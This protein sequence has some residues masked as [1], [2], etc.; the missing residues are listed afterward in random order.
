MS[1]PGNNTRRRIVPRWRDFRSTAKLGELK[2]V[3]LEEHPIK[4]SPIAEHLSYSDWKREPHL[5]NAL[6]LIGSA[7]IFDET[8]EVGD[9][10]L[11]VLLDPATPPLTKKLLSDQGRGIGREV[12]LPPNP[13]TIAGRGVIR[14]EIARIKRELSAFPWDAINWMELARNYTTV[15]VHDRAERSVRVALQLAPENRYVLRSAAR[16]F[17]HRGDLERA[18]WILFRHANSAQDPWLLAPEI[19]VASALGRTSKLAKIGQR[20]LLTDI[21]PTELTELASAL[22][23][24]EVENGNNKGAKRLLKQALMGANENS[25]AQIE[26]LNRQKLGELIDISAANPPLLHEA[27]AWA[28]T[29]KGEWHESLHHAWNWLRDQPFSSHPAMLC[30]YLLSDILELHDEAAKVCSMALLANPTEPMLQNNY[31]F[32]LVNSGKLNEATEVLSRIDIE[33][34]SGISRMVIATVG[35]LAFRTGHPEEGRQQ[36]L[37][38]IEEARKENDKVRAAR[39][40]IYLA[41]E[42]VRARTDNAAKAILRASEMSKDLENA[43]VKW[44]FAQLERMVASIHSEPPE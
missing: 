6:D 44:Q 19:A 30:S 11:Q 8:D 24:V 18:Q 29:I 38:A 34:L 1:L 31:A 16:F 37:A 35:L 4:H 23:T 14:H 12:T 15:G 41:K 20:V 32:A 43:D 13:T 7:I 21:A 3:P 28:T 22:G 26:W 36:Y 2:E 9:A 25:V 17:I 39:A 42:E 10:V 5:W 33:S 40:A 27:S